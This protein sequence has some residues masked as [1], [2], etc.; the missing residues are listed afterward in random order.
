MPKL[1]AIVAQND[2]DDFAT[3]L[4][5]GTM[6]NIQKMDVKKMMERAGYKLKPDRTFPHAGQKIEV[7]EK[8]TT[9]EETA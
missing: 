1:L 6:N 3:V 9:I 2:K 4:I 8:I 5:G 7:W